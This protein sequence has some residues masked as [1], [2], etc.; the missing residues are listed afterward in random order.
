[1]WPFWKWQTW[2]NYLKKLLMTK[3]TIQLKSL[4]HQ[5]LPFPI[6]LGRVSWIPTPRRNTHQFQTLV[7]LFHLKTYH[8]LSLL[9]TLLFQVALLLAKTNLYTLY[10]IPFCLQHPKGKKKNRRILSLLYLPASYHG[11][12]HMEHNQWVFEE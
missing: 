7:I 5:L 1:M 8:Y 4:H 2:H 6:L 9:L 11:D 3:L 12:W 10:P